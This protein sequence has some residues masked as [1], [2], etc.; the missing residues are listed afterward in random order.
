MCN[1]YQ[2]KNLFFQLTEYLV[3]INK[4]IILDP[5]STY[6]LNIGHYH[7]YNKAQKDIHNINFS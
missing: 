1:K 3:G 5:L 6:W 4:M 2:Y 7:N